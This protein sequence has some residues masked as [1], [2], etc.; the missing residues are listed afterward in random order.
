MKRA[1]IK[2]NPGDSHVSENLQ[3]PNLDDKRIRL[4]RRWRRRE[5]MVDSLNRS[6]V[7]S[8][9][10]TALKI[11]GNTDVL[12]DKNEHRIDDEAD[13]EWKTFLATYRSGEDDDD[14]EMDEDYGS[15]LATYNSDIEADCASNHSGGSN[16]DHD[17]ADAEYLSFLATYD[18]DVENDSAGNQSGGSNIDSDEIDAD[19]VSFLATYD[20]DVENDSAGN[21]SGG[22]NV[23]VNIGN[24][25]VSEEIE[26]G[27]NGFSNQFASDCISDGVDVD[28]DD[29]LLR[30]SFNV[31]QN[32][33]VS[34]QKFDTPEV[35]CVVDEDYE[36]FLNS[37]WV[38]D[39][40]FVYGCDK[41]TKNASNVEDESNSSDSD[42][43]V[44]E[45]YPNC[46]NTPF[47]SSKAY[48]SS[49]FGE[50]MHPKDNMQTTS[51]YHSQFRKRLVEYLDR[52][53]DYKE[54]KS[55]IIE[56]Y[57]RKE[58]ERHL[59]TRRGVIKSYHAVGFT[60]SY[61]DLYPD[62]AKA[63]AMESKE[64]PRVLFLLRGLF[65]WL[66][67]ASHEGQ[68]QPWRD[69]SCLEMMRKM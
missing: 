59:E 29:R 56:A 19:Y 40:D 15:F 61:L 14:D 23:D 39:G 3:S 7:A 30:K 47:V 55:L 43:V 53:Y 1:L 38:V 46:E 54:Y 66:E 22:S 5:I 52:P 67:N 8:A 42:L 48:D 18:P 60:R 6:R 20:P 2:I 57:E 4:E 9:T 65:F 64:K 25:N 33:L 16:I 44:L 32:S 69:E 17:E 37:G 34:E 12:I 50:E 27:Y 24:N 62:L 51:F 35:Q 21:H 49:C 28:E 63:I 41:N 10:T 68:F 45:S 36:Q 26:E 58:K 13:E 11:R 31:G